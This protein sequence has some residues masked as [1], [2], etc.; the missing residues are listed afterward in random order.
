MLGHHIHTLH[1]NLA[2]MRKEPLQTLMTSAVIAIALSLPATL[3]LVVENARQFESSFESFSQVTAYVQ[4]DASDKKIVAIKSQLEAMPDVESVRYISPDQ[5]L[6]EF[7]KLSGF[8][9]AL[10]HLDANPL[11]PVFVIEPKMVTPLADDIIQR[12]LAQISQVPNIDDAQIDML[13]LQRLRSL[14]QMGQQ[15]VVALGAALG[16]GVLVIVGN[17]IR[18]AIHGRRE[19]IIVVKLV[20]GTDAYVR[21]PFLYSGMLLGLMGALGASLLLVIGFWWLGASVEH[22]SELYNSQYRLI[23]PGFSGCLI[24]IGAGALL[25]LAGSWLAVG[26]HLKEIKPR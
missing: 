9:T 23:G 7:V 2:R 12:L 8:G 19:E 17:S 6:Q 18:L 15:I 21:R 16:L 11:P 22:L 4:N 3:L 25:G 1:D 24:L 20:G 5:A 13:W 10:D 14:T 26:R